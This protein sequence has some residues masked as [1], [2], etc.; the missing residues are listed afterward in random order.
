MYVTGRGGHGPGTILAALCEASREIGIDEVIVAATLEDNAPVVAEAANRLNARL[1]SKLKVD[2]LQVSKDLGESARAI[3]ARGVDAA[4][5]CV[6]DHLH[7]PAITA[8]MTAGIHVL[9]VKPFTP[10]LDEAQDLVALARRTGLYG[11]VEFHKRYDEGNLYARQAI[12]DGQ[13]GQPLYAV[14]QYSQRIVIPTEVFRG[15]AAR[16]NI[17]QYLAVHYV[18]QMWFLTGYRPHRA[19]AVGIRHVL[20]SRGIE[21]WDSV[22]ATVEWQTPAGGTFISQFNVNWIDPNTT[23]A[24]SDQKYFIVGS[25]GRLELDQK[26]RGIELIRQDQMPVSVNPYFS[27]FFPRLD[28]D[29]Q[30]FSGY[31]YQ[32]IRSFIMDIAAIRA[33]RVRPVDLERV[34]P[35]FSDALPSTSVIDAVTRSLNEQGKWTYVSASGS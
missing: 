33:G 23:T 26:H 3:A 15:W 27:E 30:R 22:H 29:T 13:I 17:F 34:R 2:Y 25:A 32:S 7:H 5:I 31:G 21:T 24:M 9:T 16:S 18:D 1:G 11:A 12:A 10:T 8:L 6:P 35:S 19:S 4:I 20:A 28:D 14:I